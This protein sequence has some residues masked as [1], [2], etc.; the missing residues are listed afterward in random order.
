MNK[1]QFVKKLSVKTTK[2]WIKYVKITYCEIRN[3]M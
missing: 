1:E 2:T 3:S